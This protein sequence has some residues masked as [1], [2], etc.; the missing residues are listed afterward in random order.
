MLE[1]DDVIAR[2][3]RRVNVDRYANMLTESCDVLYENGSDNGRLLVLNLHPWLIG[4]PF[5]INY[6]DEAL[7]TIM[8]KPLIW[9]ATGSEVTNWY[10]GH[11]KQ[12][13]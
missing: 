13:G 1:L 5:R 7:A 10:R 2:A 9:A 8:N 6:L 12:R 3:H 4:Q 11:N